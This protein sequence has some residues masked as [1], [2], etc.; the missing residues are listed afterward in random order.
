MK[1]VTVLAAT[2]SAALGQSKFTSTI[3]RLL[4]DGEVDAER[5]TVRLVVGERESDRSPDLVLVTV[6]ETE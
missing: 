2:E 3:Q 5:L 4:G 6:T 1:P